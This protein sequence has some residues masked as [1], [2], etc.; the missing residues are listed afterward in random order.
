MPG[1]KFRVVNLCKMKN[2]NLPNKPGVYKVQSKIFPKRFY[3]G[4]S[5]NI[6]A[7][8]SEHLYSLRSN[9]NSSKKLQEHFNKYGEKDI[10]F[11]VLELC[12]LSELCIKEQHYLDNSNPYFNVHKVASHKK[13]QNNNSAKRIAFKDMAGLS[14]FIRDAKTILKCCALANMMRD[15]SELYGYDYFKIMNKFCN[16]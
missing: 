1:N 15:D 10:D 16:K 14:T 13:G 5:N 7:R 8:C 3:I 2:I 11:V 9:S 6:K 12:N 4:S